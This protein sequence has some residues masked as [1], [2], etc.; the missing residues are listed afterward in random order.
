MTE[1]L[2]IFVSHPANVMALFSFLTFLTSTLRHIILTKLLLRSG[3][4]HAKVTND[5]TKF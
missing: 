5:L 4:K 2:S 3:K 1:V